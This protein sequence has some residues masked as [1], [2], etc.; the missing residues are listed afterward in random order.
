MK[1][2]KNET[3]PTHKKGLTTRESYLISA[4]AREDKH[5]FSIEDV[6]K[7]VESSPKRVMSSLISKKWVLPL[8]KGLYAIVPLDV[9]VKGADSFILHNFVIAAHLV[10]PYYIGYW[11]ALNHHGLT[12]QIPRTTFIATTKPRMPLE[13]MGN[14][15]Y[16]VRLVKKKF[17]GFTESNIEGVVVNISSPEKTIADCLD[18]P[19]HCGGIEEIAR[20]IF[21]NHT[22]LKMKEIYN[23]GMKM[24][25][26]T[27]L[28]RLGFILKSTGLL[29]EY[30]DLFKT[31]KP[32]KGYPLLD[33][34]SPRKGKH[35]SEWG[36]LINIE[37]NPERW[38]Y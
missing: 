29:N 5:I 24:G 23:M 11:S 1:K 25:N 35:D 32:S 4:L 13:I 6:K 12:E 16:F 33:P 21:F 7:L 22:D 9:G 36:L 17:F 14:E 18:H 26:N 10:E 20:A 34:L 2:Y 28:K 31:F 38:M 3:K 15:Y 19:E 8:K 37:L 27:I 30:T